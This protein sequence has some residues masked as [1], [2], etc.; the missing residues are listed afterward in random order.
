M[1]FESMWEALTG[2]LT[3]RM[4]RRQILDD[5]PMKTRPPIEE[6]KV[7]MEVE[8]DENGWFQRRA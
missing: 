7:A 2:T 8:K 6:L 4:C 1:G 3:I 5:P